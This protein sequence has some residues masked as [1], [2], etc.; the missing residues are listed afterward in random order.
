MDLAN[1][2]FV[3]KQAISKWEN[4]KSLPDVSLYPVIADMLNVSVDEL[5]GIEKKEQSNNKSQ[6]LMIFGSITIIILILV[7][8]LFLFLMPNKNYNNK[9]IEEFL[10]NQTEK[11]LNI[12][13]PEIEKYDLIQ[14]N[15]WAIYNNSIYP[16]EM[17]YFIFKDEIINV[18]ETW[19]E[20]LPKE[21]IEIIPVGSS[22][23]PYICD[24]FK[25]IDLTNN[26]VNQIELNDSK[27]HEYVLYCLQIQNKRLI[28]I[29]FEV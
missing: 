23:Y 3:T 24:Y 5:M 21:M 17:Y 8:S 16:T 18:D 26:K 28:A 7:V 2:L 29:K 22:E 11:D 10:I 19:L 12:K 9:R 25:L 14:Y 1:K 4:D 20:E 15:S 6:K 27:E 13:M